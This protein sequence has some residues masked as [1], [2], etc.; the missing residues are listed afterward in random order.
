MAEATWTARRAEGGAPPAASL[1]ADDAVAASIRHCH[2]VARRCAR[3]FYY[4]L[5]LTP[6]P[7]RSAVYAIY[8]F[9]RACDDLVDAAPDQPPLP[10]REGHARIDAFRST[11]DQVLAGGPLP[12]VPPHASI[13]PAFRWVM[14]SF[15][16]EPRHLHEMLDGQQ[17]DLVTLRYD[18]WDQLYRYCYKVASV[19]GL[20]CVRVWGTASDASTR[21]IGKLSEYRGIAFQL[22]NILRD[23]VED[24]DRGRVYLPV[25]DLQ[26]F[27]YTVHDLRQRVA[28]EPF[29]RLMQF[30][31][32]RARSYYQMS[33]MLEKHIDPSCRQASW[34]L[35]RIY[36]GLLERIAARPRRVLTGR[37]RLGS[38]QKAAIAFTAAWRARRA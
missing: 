17:C 9:M 14:R 35:L 28:S 32:E 7:K 2:A 3:N 5:K 31:I 8:A 33:A 24:A 27:G 25:E 1:P 26:R 10:V 13:W 15:P 23:V 36:S 30:E 18:T 4:G 11:M 22:T 20:T 16:V 29:D 21:E 19:V 34:A 6:E 12:E 37:V 38:M